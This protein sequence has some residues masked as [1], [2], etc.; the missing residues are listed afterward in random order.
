M[1]SGGGTTKEGGHGSRISGAGEAWVDKGWGAQGTG[2]AWTRAGGVSVGS[3]R[4][5]CWGVERHRVNVAS[6]GDRGVW[7]SMNLTLDVS[8]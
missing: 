5:G 8:Q 2:T 4:V 6:G 3:K 7:R 1:Q